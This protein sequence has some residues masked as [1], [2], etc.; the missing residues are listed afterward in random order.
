MIKTLALIAPPTIDYRAK[1]S[2]RFAVLKEAKY[3]VTHKQS[4]AENIALSRFMA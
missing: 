4:Q 1:T 3:I 2:P